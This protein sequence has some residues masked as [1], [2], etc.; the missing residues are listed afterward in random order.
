MNNEWIK[1]YACAIAVFIKAHGH[2]SELDDV[3]KAGLTIERCIEAD[4]DEHDL[5]ILKECFK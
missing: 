1:G 5:E 2:S 3:F 4:V